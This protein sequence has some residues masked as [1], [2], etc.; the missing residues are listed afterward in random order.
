VTPRE[1]MLKAF[2]FDDPDRLPVFYHPSPAGLYVHGQKLLELFREYPPD[3][4]VTFE[5]P[6]PPPEAFDADGRYH[7]FK[8]DELGTVWEYRIVGVTG[9]PHEYA[10]RSAADVDRYEF[11]ATPTCS[12]E[13]FERERRRIEGLKRTYLTFGGGGSIFERLHALR[14][15]EEI[16]MD[17]TLAEPVTMRLLDRL[18]DYQRRNLEH[19]L[20]VGTDV[21]TFGDDWGTQDSL[22]ISPEVFRRVFKPRLAAL[23]EPVRRAGRKILYHS[24]GAVHPLYGDLVEIGINGLWHQIGLYDAEAFAKEAAANR[25][26]LFL[27]M[28]RQRLI[29]LGTPGQIRE[30]VRRYT[31]IHR[32]LGGGAIHYVEVENDAPFENV[33]AWVKA[34]NGC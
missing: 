23:M 27:H 8:K 2:A 5:I 1:R 14:P 3:N 6:R 30:T 7:E 10:I 34:V 13:A 26:V 17:V 32:R 9:H 24:C 33:E 25:T 28:D 29:P 4:V 19:A 15:F 31:D 18:V 20:A 16:L 11:P 21:I 22:L 12:G